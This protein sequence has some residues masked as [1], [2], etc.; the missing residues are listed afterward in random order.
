MPTPTASVHTEAEQH[1]NMAMNLTRH[2][3]NESLAQGLG[4]VVANA[5]IAWLLLRNRDELAL[6]AFDGVAFDVALTCLLLLMIVSW[7]VMASNK[8]KLSVG[9]LDPITPNANSFFQRLVLQLPDSVWK[10][11]A[12]IGVLGLATV[13]P[14]TLLSFQLLDVLSIAP[15]HYVIFKALWTGA[16]ASLVVTPCVYAVLLRG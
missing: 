6:W 1:S 12:C 15:M 11:G 3:R 16:M 13:A 10:A 7:I 14:L 9:K 5:L 8:K 2:I 4:N